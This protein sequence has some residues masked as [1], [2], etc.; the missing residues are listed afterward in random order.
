MVTPAPAREP[1]FRRRDP[2]S[3]ARCRPVDPSAAVAGHV[4]RKKTSRHQRRPLLMVQQLLTDVALEGPPLPALSRTGKRRGVDSAVR[5]FSLALVSVILI[6]T[7]TSVTT[8]F[9]A[10]G[11]RLND[12][13]HINDSSNIHNINS[14]A[15]HYQALS[16]TREPDVAARSDSERL[17]PPALSAGQRR[18][19]SPP[20]LSDDD[21]S[22]S[23]TSSSADRGTDGAISGVV[24]LVASKRSGPFW[25]FTNNPA[26]PTENENDEEPNLFADDLYR[27][28]DENGDAKRSWPMFNLWKTDAPPPR[29]GS[30]D[31]SQQQPPAALRTQI[32]YRYY[33]RARNTATAGGGRSAA[34]ARVPF[35]LF[36]PNVDHWKVTGQQL[37]ARGY[38]VIA[39]GPAAPS[40]PPRRRR[41]Q[42]PD[43]DDDDDARRQQQQYRA[44]GAGLVRQLLDA[45]RWPKVVVVACDGEAAALAIQAT[46]QLAPE[47]RVAGLIL[48]GR[49]HESDSDSDNPDDDDDGDDGSSKNS[50]DKHSYALLREILGSR[51]GPMELERFLREQLPCPFTVVCD[52]HDSRN[53]NQASSDDFDAATAAAASAPTRRAHHD[54]EPHRSVIIG[55]GAAPHRRRPGYF[56][57][58]LSRFVE[59]HVAPAVVAP[60]PK[61]PRSVRQ[62][63]RAA[64][65]A[66]AAGPEHS[67]WRVVDEMFN[68]EGMVVFGRLAATAVFYAVTLKVLFY[69]YD[70]VRE[71]VYLITSAKRKT[72]ATVQNRWSNLVS[73]FTFVWRLPTLFR[74]FRSGARGGGD[75]PRDAKTKVES[76][77]VDDLDSEECDPPSESDA[78]PPPPPASDSEAH[79][80]PMFFLDHVVT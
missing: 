41:P 66:S 27:N 47:Q 72:V 17:I 21:V 73:F 55:G 16:T 2:C 51:H 75:A 67:P 14:A 1:R 31:D 39:V 62:H 63:R 70:N 43:D 52:G 49:V 53:P 30:T 26:E 42:H 45:L 28:N 38:N 22:T 80:P 7:N 33:A 20:C 77:A 76:D 54:Q 29:R 11:R 24:A 61:A 74:R 3:L 57:W 78:P 6:A 34:A 36:G 4:G 60:P 65:R 64:D 79:L 71:G 25:S 56:A 32:V 5:L 23:T 46:L 68:E 19:S 18:R 48:C 58:V 9:G 59:E 10:E 69:Q 37:S 13:H 15:R 8:M 35:L 12:D 44:Q 40:K 50:E